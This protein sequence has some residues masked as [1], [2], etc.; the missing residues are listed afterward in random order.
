MELFCT[1][2]ICMANSALFG[3][4]HKFFS[5]AYTRIS[6]THYSQGHEKILDVN[7]TIIN[8]G[9]NEH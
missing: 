6:L 1:T 3:L 2:K 9:Q 7:L 4:Q 8:F 5:K